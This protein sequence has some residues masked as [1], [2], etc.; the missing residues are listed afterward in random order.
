MLFGL[1]K[2]AAPFR[3]GRLRRIG[4]GIAQVLCDLPRR[5]AVES[6]GQRVTVLAGL[7]I[8]GQLG[9]LVE[10]IVLRLRGGVLGA[11]KDHH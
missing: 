3:A 4:A 8:V 11:S 9:K 7:Q 1:I 10:D 6:S 2:A 5:L